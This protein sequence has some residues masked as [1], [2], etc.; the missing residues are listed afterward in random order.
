MNVDEQMV[1]TA[2][3]H[4]LPLLEGEVWSM[5]V[6]HDDGCPHRPCG[7]RPEVLFRRASDQRLLYRLILIGDELSIERNELASH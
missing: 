7:C 2:M 1:L 4:L 3:P 6:Y 5:T